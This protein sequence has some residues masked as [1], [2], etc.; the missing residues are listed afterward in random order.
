MKKGFRRALGLVCSG[1]LLLSVLPTPAMAAAGTGL[2]V[3]G[4]DALVVN[5]TSFLV[6]TRI[7]TIIYICCSINFSDP[8]ISCISHYC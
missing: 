1:A 2:T 6:C 7:G 8:S 3:S 5:S 4:Q